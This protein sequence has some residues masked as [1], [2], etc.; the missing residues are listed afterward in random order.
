MNTSGYEVIECTDLWKMLESMTEHIREHRHMLVSMDNPKDRQIGFQ[1]RGSDPNHKWWKLPLSVIAATDFSKDP[2][3]AELVK[4]KLGRFVLGN[5]VEIKVAH[6][7]SERLGKPTGCAYEFHQEVFSHI[8]ESDGS[9]LFRLG[10]L[11]GLEFDEVISMA[12]ECC[13]VLVDEVLSRAGGKRQEQWEKYPPTVF[14]DSA[15]ALSEFTPD[16]SPEVL[17]QSK[18]S[19][20]VYLLPRET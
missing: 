11:L 19:K 14:S 12:L 16:R 6:E 1:T 15:H 10:S 9:R 13:E 3:V 18:A 17:S 5:S 8:R 4:T 2:V 20:D 7:R